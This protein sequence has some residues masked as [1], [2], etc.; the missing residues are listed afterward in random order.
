M[1]VKELTANVDLQFTE[2]HYTSD[3]K[4]HDEVSV[5]RHVASASQADCRSGSNNSRILT[6]DGVVPEG[7]CR[8]GR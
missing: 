1:S 5:G 7:R 2:V 8:H 4:L 3:R 6:A